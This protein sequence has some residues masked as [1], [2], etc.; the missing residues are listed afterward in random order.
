MIRRG[1]LSLM[2]SLPDVT[3]QAMARLPCRE[4]P[5][6]KE[7]DVSLVSTSALVTGE[8]TGRS[9]DH[10]R[11]LIVIVPAADPHLFE[12]ATRHPADGYLMQAELSAPALQDAIAQVRQG[13]LAVPDTVAAYLLGRSRGDEPVLLPQ[14]QR[15]SSR[16]AE[17]LSLLVTGA[18]NKE[19]AHSTGMS[20]HGVKRHVSAL[21]GQFHSPSRV[22]LVSLLLQSGAIRA[23]GLPA[24][25]TPKVP[26]QRP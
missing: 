10:L 7:A 8:R 16:G 19:I 24:A 9:L 6:S 26:A 11:P 12:T 23:D 20:V 3:A 5:A 15:L 22:H 14:L 21:L 13:R 4:D 25:P 1:L 17:V 18:S 2:A